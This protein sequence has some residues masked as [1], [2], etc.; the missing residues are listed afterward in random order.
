MKNKR[1][2]LLCLLLSGV[3][4]FQLSTFNSQLSTLNFPLSALWAQKEAHITLNL[5]GLQTGDSITL[6]WG[7]FNKPTSPLILQVPIQEESTLRVPLNEPRLIIIGLKGYDGGY[8]LLAS[9][10][11]T[12]RIAGRVHKSKNGRHP[13]VDFP[14]MD[15][16]GATWQQPYQNAM[17]DYMMHLDSLT[18]CVN[19]DF[20]D[21]QRTIRKAKDEK[22]EQTIADM[23]QTIMGRNYIGRV[24]DN[25]NDMAGYFKEMVLRQKQNFLAP[26]LMLRYG[27]NLDK[28]DRP[29]YDALSDEAKTSYYGREVKDA[30]Y[31]PSMIGNIAPTVAVMTRDGKE[32]LLSFTHQTNRY[33]LLDFWASWCAPCLKEVPNL[34]RLHEKYHDKGLDIIGLSVDRNYADWT[35]TLDE[36]DEPWC[37]Y[38]DIDKQAIM[39][40]QVQYIPSIFIMDANGKIIAEKL[41]GNDL[42]DFIDSLFAE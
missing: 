13:S 24:T 33:L 1:L 4:N 5:K 2:Y 11:E 21:I 12:I 38:I 20:R 23:Y 10:E 36:M 28:S 18:A 31:P 8:E 25:Y 39:E 30:V 34:K 35:E 14:K 22:D 27:G 41:R 29:L 6:S 17:A 40:Y 42:S 16:Q 32:K 26:L 3:A 15:V 7:T 19:N 37:N 9:P